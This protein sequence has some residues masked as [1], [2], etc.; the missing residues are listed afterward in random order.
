M[1]GS[2]P[3]E[4]RSV[5]C[6]FSS[7]GEPEDYLLM[8]LLYNEDNCLHECLIRHCPAGNY[9]AELG[10]IL[11][12]FYV[13]GKKWKPLGIDSL[14]GLQIRFISYRKSDHFASVGTF[15]QRSDFHQ[16]DSQSR[17]LHIASKVNQ[18]VELV[19]QKLQHKDIIC[20]FDR[21]LSDVSAALEDFKR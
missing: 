2:H 21:L 17:R 3:S 16:I 11:I 20:D 5:V 1:E 6:F 13:E 19:I 10:G 18:C 15:I 4:P 9:G 12:E 14:K 8:N 7:V